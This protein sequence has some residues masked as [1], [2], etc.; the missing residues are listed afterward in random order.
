MTEQRTLSLRAAAFA[1]AVSLLVGVLASL[2]IR[3]PGAS[4]V[5]PTKITA[6]VAKEKVHWKLPIAVGTNLQALG[7]NVLY[8]AGILERGSDGALQLDVYEPGKLVPPFSIVDAV[9]EQKVEAGYTWLGYD[10]GKIPASP[11]ISAVPF[12]FEPW[13]FMGWWYEGGG[14]ELAEA[15][16]HR[17][18]IHPLLC[19]LIGPETAG[20]FRQPINGLDD[21]KGLKIRF[22]GLV[23]D[24]ALGLE[25]VARFNYYPGWHQP[26]T[27][28]HMVINLELWN[29]LSTANRNLLEMA[30]TAGVTRNLARSEALQGAIV[31]DYPAKGVTAGILSRDMLEELRR[32]TEAVLE[33][34][35][36][37]D[38][39]FAEILASQ[40]AF[41]EQYRHW[42]RVA[43][44]PRDF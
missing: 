29:G 25:R 5:A 12:G 35:A 8:V 17:Y 27:A 30:C 2:A 31:A 20:W 43:Y 40:R 28:F 15:L 19:G 22:A 18:A 9:R 36:Q 1:V 11:L 38:A 26:F 13:E 3:P 37:Q 24:Q 42:K 16:Y 41:R 14:R 21:L 7:D 34:A 4:A 6:A 23:V 44:L 10:Q 39:D 33:E 32:G